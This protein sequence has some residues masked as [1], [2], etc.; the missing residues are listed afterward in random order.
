M[1]FAVTVDRH[2]LPKPVE[3]LFQNQKLHKVPF[4]TGINTDEGGWLLP[5]VCSQ[6]MKYFPR[7]V[8]C[9]QDKVGEWFVFLPQF[10]APPNWTEGM[11]RGEVLPFLSMIFPDVRKT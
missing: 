7:L 9:L 2:F 4:M 8:K 1:R 6:K 3:E 5:G 10:L 11:D